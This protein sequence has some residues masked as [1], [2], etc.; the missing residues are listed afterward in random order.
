MSSKVHPA[1]V[2][3]NSLHSNDCMDKARREHLR[4]KS[5]LRSSVNPVKYEREDLTNITTKIVIP[6]EVK[7][8]V[9]IQ[10]EIGQE[11]YTRSVESTSTKVKKVQL[12]MWKSARR[13]VTHKLDDQVHEC[14]DKRSLF[15]HMLIV[16][17][18]YPEIRLKEDIESTRDEN[19]NTKKSQPFEFE[20]Q[21]ASDCKGSFPNNRKVGWLK[22]DSQTILS[23]QKR[24]VT[25]NTRI[26]VT[27]DEHRT[28]NLH[29]RQV[30]E[31][32]RGCY[33]CQINTPIMKNRVGCIEVHA[34][35]WVAGGN[36]TLENVSRN[37]M[38]AYLCIASN[39]V[40]PSVSKRIIV[41][42]NF[43]PV[44]KVDN[45]LI[46]APLGTA[47][48]V[49]C[50]VE[51]F[52]KA[53]N[54]WER[55]NGEMMLNNKKYELLEMLDA[56]RVTMQLTIRNF[57]REDEGKYRC[58][59]T[60]SLGKAETSIRIYVIEVFTAKPTTA[61]AYNSFQT[62][63]HSKMSNAIDTR[64]R[65][66]QSKIRDGTLGLDGATVSLGMDLSDN[67]QNRQRQMQRLDQTGEGRAGNGVGIL[68][69]PF[70]Q[71]E[72]ENH[73][74][75]GGGGGVGG[76][77][78][79]TAKSSISTLWMNIFLLKILSTWR[80]VQLTHGDVFL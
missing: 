75:A 25:H 35:D 69:G 3:T 68:G 63:T 19:R 44:V 70:Q 57:T 41:N 16:A 13:S 22:V 15:V 1:A 54:Y 27:H 56:Y 30:K 17:C 10:E 71:G 65:E 20:E 5:V 23:L 14:K 31:S 6:A 58:I 36:L 76:S 51:A 28:W 50:K 59:S 74:G 7:K 49:E 55:E 2:R 80:L 46:G 52:P 47:V 67:K 4:L 37:Q 9:H 42:V 79:T 66:G 29:I 43:S 38:G 32:D 34:V 78:S 18:S 77:S 11:M 40:P 62:T 33:M 48:T 21:K 39:K 64:K 73:P 45:Q 8:G 26:S 72:E 12:K 24:V 53:V 60:N 61:T